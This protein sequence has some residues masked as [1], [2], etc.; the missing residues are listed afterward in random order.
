[1]I[2]KCDRDSCAQIVVLIVRKHRASCGGICFFCLVILCNAKSAA[3]YLSDSLRDGW[4]DSSS[5]SHSGRERREFA[6]CT[7]N[8]QKTAGKFGY[9][10]PMWLTFWESLGRSLLALSQLEPCELGTHR[11]EFDDLTKF[12]RVRCADHF[13]EGQSI[14]VGG[15]K[16]T[17]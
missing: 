16:G 2:F 17:F 3:W 14:R 15:G 11:I 6:R 1:M 12:R 13:G 8:L 4:P 9:D 10:H 7:S 5:F